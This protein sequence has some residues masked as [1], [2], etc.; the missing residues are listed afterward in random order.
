MTVERLQARFPDRNLDPDRIV[1]LEDTPA[2]IRSAQGAGLRV[3]GVGQSL[4]LE[5]LEA[6]ELRVPSLEGL[7]GKRFLECCGDLLGDPA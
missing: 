3:I 5:E 4:P 2:G 6:A 7:A 1:V